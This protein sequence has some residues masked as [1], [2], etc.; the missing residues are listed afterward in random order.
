VDATLAAKATAKTQPPRL[1]LHENAPIANAV[2]LNV[3]GQL[4]LGLLRHLQPAMQSG[5]RDTQLLG[6]MIQLLLTKR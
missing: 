5:E 2:A 1:R 3:L 6:P 4:K